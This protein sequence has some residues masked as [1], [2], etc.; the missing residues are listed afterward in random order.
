MSLPSWPEI[1]EWLIKTGRANP[2]AH[3]LAHD[4]YHYIMKAH[5]E[6]YHYAQEEKKNPQPPKATEG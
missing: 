6:S 5:L 2:K 3:Q 1:K 4:V